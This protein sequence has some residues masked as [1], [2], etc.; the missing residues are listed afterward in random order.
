VTLH[1]LHVVTP[2]TPFAYEYPIDTGDILR[3]AQQ[4][5]AEELKRLVARAAEA[6]VPANSQGR[7]PKPFTF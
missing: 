3:S 7:F 4:A 2:I 6:G 1:L 5:A